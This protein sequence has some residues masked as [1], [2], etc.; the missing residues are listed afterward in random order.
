MNL[1]RIEQAKI[2]GQYD[3]SVFARE[4]LP[5][6]YETAKAKFHE[7]LYDRFMEVISDP[8]P[9]HSVIAAPRK[10][11]KSTVIVTIFVLWCICYCE[12]A[13]KYCIVI[14]SD[15]G[16]QAKERLA[17]IAQELE[18]NERLRAAFGDGISEGRK[19]TENIIVTKSGIKVSAFGT[20]A[21]M[22]G[23]K[24]R[25]KEPDLLIGDDLENDENVNTFEQRN[26][27]DNWFFRTFCKAAG[28]RADIF[29]LGT[30][31]HYDSLLARLLNNPTFW[32]RKYQGIV[33]WASQTKLWDEWERLYTDWG[34]PEQARKLAAQKFYEQNTERLLDGAV[35]LWPERKPYLALMK[36]RVKEGPASFDSEIQNEPINPED[37]LFQDEWFTWFDEEEIDVKNM[38]IVAAVDPSL[39]KS[40]KHGDPSAIISIARGPNGILYVLD[41][42]IERR[43]PDKIIEDCIELYQRR[44]LSILGV[45]TVQFQEFFKDQLLKSANERG[46]Y[47][48]VHGIQ[49]SKDK[50]M[51]IQ[52]LQPLF[53]SGRL[54]LQKKHKR[55]YEQLKFFPK[56]DHDDGPDALEMA[57]AMVERISMT[58]HSAGKRNGRRDN[59]NLKRVFG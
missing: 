36:L 5:H 49:Q 15:S 45:E 38:P 17:E 20:G 14:G 13:R 9:T 8:D 34:L 19:W 28:T 56:A 43:P 4:F 39:G 27:T 59:T 35:T 22:L 50:V 25:E 23:T 55:L 40:N 58:Y 42:D 52:K 12:L 46:L 30:I 37:C 16:P 11:A 7:E 32:V 21:S 3:I 48:P 33:H 57:V 26:K 47:P 10:H 53:K 2:A 51:R 29:V 44:N 1:T 6:Y 18:D 41:A 54:K 24:N 31:K